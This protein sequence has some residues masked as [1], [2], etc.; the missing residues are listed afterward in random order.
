MLVSM[1][2]VEVLFKVNLHVCY[3]LF[4]VYI[5]LLEK[6]MEAGEMTQSLKD[7]LTTKNI[8]KKK[9]TNGRSL[10]PF[11]FKFQNQSFQKPIIL[12]FILYFQTKKKIHISFHF[13]L[14]RIVH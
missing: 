2:L 4:L 11:V 10:L 12:L 6:T 3:R 7:G 8:I 14:S 5:G 1:D 9:K 13:S